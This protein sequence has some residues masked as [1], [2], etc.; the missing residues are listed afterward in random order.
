MRQKR[1]QTA[2]TN[3]QPD[4]LLD[5]GDRFHGPEVGVEGHL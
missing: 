5:G 1:L 4:H 2:N 3:L